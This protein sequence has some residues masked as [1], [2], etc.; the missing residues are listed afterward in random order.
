MHQR[1]VIAMGI[2][3]PTLNIIFGMHQSLQI[4]QTPLH[5]DLVCLDLL[6]QGLKGIPSPG[7]KGVEKLVEQDSRTEQPISPGSA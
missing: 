4:V 1:D 6:G 7:I 5:D 2:A 3:Q